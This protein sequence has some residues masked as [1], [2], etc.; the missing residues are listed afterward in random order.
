MFRLTSSL[1]LKECCLLTLYAIDYSAVL[2]NV[3][4]M[5]SIHLEVL[6]PKLINSEQVV[7]FHGW[8]NTDKN[9]IVL[10]TLCG[11]RLNSVSQ[12]RSSFGC[13]SHPLFF[14]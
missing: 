2:L 11:Q 8:H 1:C 10:P 9:H 13:Q 5:P 12:E 14:L 4:K 7:F 6:I 3:T